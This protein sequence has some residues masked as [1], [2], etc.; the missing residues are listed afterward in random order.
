MGG[1]RN[2]HEIDNATRV[3]GRPNGY[4]DGHV[5][6]DLPAAR[7]S[8][9][10]NPTIIAGNDAIVN[11][12]YDSLLLLQ[13]RCSG[14]CSW[15][16]AVRRS[17]AVQLATARWSQRSQLLNHGF[18]RRTIPARRNKLQEGRTVNPSPYTYAVSNLHLRPQ[19]ASS[20]SEDSE[21]IT[22]SSIMTE[23]QPE[24]SGSDQIVRLLKPLALNV[25]ANYW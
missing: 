1:A 2:E 24:S 23:N 21:V 12:G 6:H 9:S 5:F 15:S 17:S 10:V 14:W 7:L 11:V 22:Y 25:I 20:T 18:C 13:E 4:T 3:Q 8:P 19:T 16:R